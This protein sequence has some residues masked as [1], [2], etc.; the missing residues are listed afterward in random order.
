MDAPQLVDISEV[1][2]EPATSDTAKKRTPSIDDDTHVSPLPNKKKPKTPPTEIM[3][4]LETLGVRPGCAI[5]AIAACVMDKKRMGDPAHQFYQ[6]VKPLTDRGFHSDPTTIAWWEKQD[7]KARDI[8]EHD[9]IPISSALAAFHVWAE[10]YPEPRRFWACGPHFDFSIYAEACR[11][12]DVT[13]AF[14]FYDVR[15]TRTALDMAGISKKDADEMIPDDVRKTIV[16]H[17]ALSDCIQQTY[18]VWFARDCV[19]THSG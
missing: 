18:H 9:Q 3:V 2:A 10:K 7:A 8:L 11:L 13:P 6:N 16:P 4:D 14:K 5:I 1:E 19:S 17:H 15:D 12:V